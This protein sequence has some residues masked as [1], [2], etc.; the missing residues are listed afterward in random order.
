MVQPCFLPGA[1]GSWNS[2]ISRA[3]QVHSTQQ[4]CASQRLH[5]VIEQAGFDPTEDTGGQKLNSLERLLELGKEQTHWHHLLPLH[6]LLLHS[7]TASAPLHPIPRPTASLTPN[8]VSPTDMLMLHQLCCTLSP[9]MHTAYMASAPV[10]TV[11]HR[12]ILVNMHT[13]EAVIFPNPSAKSKP[14]ISGSPV[15]ISSWAVLQ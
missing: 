4:S 13:A 3:A 6:N 7:H 8:T 11:T 15:F 2:G 14:K 1:T 10:L 5:L 12:C 9:S